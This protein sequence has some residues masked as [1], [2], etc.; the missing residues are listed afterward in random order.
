LKNKDLKNF[1]SPV[2]PSVAP[3]VG[4]D[5]KTTLLEALRRVDRETL[6]LVLAELLRGG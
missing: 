1:L 6:A 3:A 2:A 5:L 4:I